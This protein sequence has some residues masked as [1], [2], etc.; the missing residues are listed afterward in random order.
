[1]LDVPLS[2][3]GGFALAQTVDRESVFKQHRVRILY[4][5]V[6]SGLIFLAVLIDSR[7]S[8]MLEKLGRRKIRLD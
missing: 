3:A 2:T 8:S 4:P 6:A 7:R 1:M 5:L